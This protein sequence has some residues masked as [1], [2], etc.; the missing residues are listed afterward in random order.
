M[1]LNPSIF[2]LHYNVTLYYQETG[3]PGSVFPFKFGDQIKL[4]A[5][6]IWNVVLL[7]ACLAEPDAG[8]CSGRYPRYYYNPATYRCERFVYGGCS[9]NSNNYLTLQQCEEKCNSDRG[10]AQL[11][12]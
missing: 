7:V 11:G 6:C 4:D 5:V 3:Q 1:N 10:S 9:G 12:K 2:P 8:P